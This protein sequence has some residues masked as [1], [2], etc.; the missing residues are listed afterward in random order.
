MAKSDKDLDKD[1]KALEAGLKKLPT[2][3]ELR[4]AIALLGKMRPG[5]KKVSAIASKID[6]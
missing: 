2:E 1:V 3:A 4:K 5:L 6:S